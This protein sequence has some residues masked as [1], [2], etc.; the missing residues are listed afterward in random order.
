MHLKAQRPIFV[1]AEFC[2]EIEQLSKAALMD[3][4]W[5]YAQRSCEGG[6]AADPARVMSEFRDT[7]EVILTHREIIFTNLKRAKS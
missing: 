7:R 1:P 3:M 2:G 4:V 5:D 6:V